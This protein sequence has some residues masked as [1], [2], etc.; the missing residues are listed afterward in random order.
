[1]MKENDNPIFQFDTYSFSDLNMANIVN[2]YVYEL[3]TKLEY[4]HN[5]LYTKLNFFKKLVSSFMLNVSISDV[6][7]DYLLKIYTSIDKNLE[8]EMNGFLIYLSQNKLIADNISKR[9]LYFENRIKTQFYSGNIIYLLTSDIFIPF[10]E[11]FPD[12]NNEQTSR[13]FFMAI[14][15][16]TNDP[17]LTN[18]LS[19]YIERMK[20]NCDF[21]LSQRI[22]IISSLLK[23]FKNH[24]NISIQ[25]LTREHFQF[26]LSNNLLNIREL[27]YTIQFILYLYELNALVDENL[28][29][30]CALLKSGNNFIHLSK[31]FIEYV[32]NPF[33]HR[34]IVVEQKNASYTNFVHIIP[35]IKNDFIFSIIKEYS[36]NILNTNTSALKLVLTNF[37]TSLKGLEIHEIT[38]FTLTTFITQI[39]FFRENGSSNKVLNLICDIYLFI[40][41]KYYTNIFENDH[42]SN[43]ILL[44]TGLGSYLNE[45]YD[46]IAYNP[47]E[48]IP[49]SDKWILNFSNSNVGNSM[50]SAS[51]STV[52][53]FSLIQNEVYRYWYKFYVWK[54]SSDLYSKIQMKTHI[55]RFFNHINDLKTGKLYSIYTKPNEDIGISIEEILSYKTFIDNSVINN[56]TK[57][58]C[59][60]APRTVLKFIQENNIFDLHNGIFYYLTNVL[61]TNYDN[62]KSIP[63]EEL[64]K[65]SALIKDK[66][67]NDP[68]ITI[69]YLIFYIALE[70]E[71]R[72]S[73]IL[74]LQ[75]DCIKEVS[76]ANQY[77]LVSKTKTSKNAKIEQPI[78][79]YVK[80]H[81][82]EIIKLTQPYRDDCSNAELKN[83][84]FLVPNFSRKNAY[85]I[86][87]AANFNSFFKLCCQELSLPVYTLSNLRDTHMTMAEE[88]VIRNQLS[89]LEQSILSG[90]KSTNVDNKHYVDTQIKELLESV[91]GIIIGSVNL[92]GEILEIIPSNLAT[93]EN[94]VANQCGYCS[95]RSCNDT[96][97]LSCLLCNSFVTTLDRL[98]FFEEQVKIMDE[99]IKNST[100]PH[101]I[102]DFSNIKLLNLEYIYSILKLKSQLE[103]TS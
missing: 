63:H 98:P 103:Q 36:Q 92:N 79:I 75:I 66:A 31:R 8:R 41:D 9:V 67:N 71:F 54:S 68:I 48:D 47:I 83:F 93:N 90:H 84:L 88:Y 95:T 32:N 24:L 44:R 12:A 55:I 25:D 26:L 39:N 99:K 2:S 101:D 94:S 30:I 86:I 6:T 42:I 21:A 89:D 3:Q 69:Y 60:Y 56:R 16:N 4:T 14:S 17:F 76:K 70:T 40:M 77:V 81:I 85:R 38:D 28:K 73:Q 64:N 35:E 22:N 7:T 96:S 10:I 43:N 1:M 80:K 50:T 72:V 27:F 23:T 29:N 53:D 51:E 61:D 100:L 52:I 58:G 78:T 19:N 13:L 59:I 87:T 18:L 57:N 5:T 65:I 37:E 15:F 46:L 49:S 33:I 74:S 45:G 82:E 11:E 91:H 97:Y 20:I 34:Y 62:T 102:E